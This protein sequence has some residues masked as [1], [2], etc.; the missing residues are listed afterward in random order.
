[1]NNFDHLGRQIGNKID[2]PA[3][4]TILRR[5]GRRDLKD[6]ETIGFRPLLPSPRVKPTKPAMV[7]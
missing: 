5:V 7:E 3:R 4:M 1:M 6:L 2:V